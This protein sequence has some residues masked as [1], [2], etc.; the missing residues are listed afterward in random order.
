MD[1]NLPRPICVSRARRS[2]HQP[3]R[4]E[5][6]WAFVDYAVHFPLTYVSSW[7]ACPQV[8]SRR[9]FFRF[10]PN[11]SREDLERILV[12]STISSILHLRYRHFSIA[13]FVMRVALTRSK[14]SQLLSCISRIAYNV[15]GWSSYPSFSFH[16]PDPMACGRNHKR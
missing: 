14:I 3:H 6:Q 1:R 11:S 16:M 5:H 9:I 13:V 12:R 2:S 8:S 4:E 15:I 7:S 10:L